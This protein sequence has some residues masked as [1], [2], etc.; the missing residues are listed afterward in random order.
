[1]TT[2]IARVSESSSGDGGGGAAA[3]HRAVFCCPCSERVDGPPSRN[4]A[5]CHVFA[6][7]A[8]TIPIPHFSRCLYMSPHI[9]E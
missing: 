6:Q 7:S 5:G 4:S 1:M 8:P 3:K 9:N 2:W